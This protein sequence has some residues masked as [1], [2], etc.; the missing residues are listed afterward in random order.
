MFLGTLTH[1]RITQIIF[2]SLTILF[3]LLEIGDFT[4]IHIIKTIAGF[5]GIFCG[6]SAIYSAVAQIVNGEFKKTVFPL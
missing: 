1:N 2:L 6:C 4:E 3:F 5:V